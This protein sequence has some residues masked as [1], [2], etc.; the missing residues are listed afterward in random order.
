[1]KTPTN[2]QNTDEKKI[3]LFMSENG[4]S[5]EV[6]TEAPIGSDEHYQEL[7]LSELDYIL[8]EISRVQQQMN[9]TEE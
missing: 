7:E 8:D 9:D 2:Q 6:L 4:I 1:M 5:L 3:Y